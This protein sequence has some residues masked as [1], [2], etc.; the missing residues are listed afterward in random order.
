M[1]QI[2][3]FGV[4]SALA[5]LGLM[6][7][8]G[9]KEEV[10]D[11]GDLHALTGPCAAGTTVQTQSA[12]GIVNF[13]HANLKDG[14]GQPILV[15]ALSNGVKGVCQ[16][17]AGD[18]ALVALN[19]EG[20]I[21][22]QFLRV[23]STGQPLGTAA[24]TPGTALIV[25]GT[26]V[27]FRSVSNPTTV[28]RTLPTSMEVV[29]RGDDAANGRSRVSER[30]L[31]HRTVLSV[32]G[33][34]PPGGTPTG[35]L[36][37]N[38]VSILFP[39]IDSQLIKVTEAG[40]KGALWPQALFT[41]VVATGKSQAQVTFNDSIDPNNI[42]NWKIVSFRYDP[43]FPRMNSANPADCKFELRLVAQPAAGNNTADMTA[44]LIYHP[45]L[46]QREAIA[47]ELLALKKAS[48]VS[49][50]GALG[51]HPG[52]KSNSAA[53][54]KLVKDFVLRNMGASNLTQVAFMGTR[55]SDPWVFFGG[56]VSNGNYTLFSIP[57]TNGAKVQSTFAENSV[58]PRPSGASTAALLEGA[59]PTQAL[60][61]NVMK[62]ENPNVHTQGSVDCVSC[63]TAVRVIERE[64]SAAQTFVNNSQF[65]FPA[66]AGIST[67]VASGQ[68]STQ[69]YSVRNF[70]YFFKQA[71]I[72][73][74]TAN[75][76]AA[77]TNFTNKNILKVP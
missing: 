20:L 49:T 3:K 19:E 69:L 30:G 57:N 37:T 40:A 46:S 23:K 76:S 12:D 74:R 43:C 73:Q 39:L 29:C 48:P 52:L 41:K 10:N 62:I 18:F 2:Q 64:R 32:A 22:K 77:V 34:T 75:E 54:T 56:S 15:R 35:K 6:S 68:L 33:G 67:A 44:H 59:A 63:H 8:C 51:V 38:D 47:K 24:C 55:N 58:T 4:S 72:A 25:T 14:N 17:N 60:V 21:S 66:P 61:D 1:L 70:G 28:L 65:R 50:S 42:A 11:S 31:L 13:R 26:D 53:Y 16:A 5:L 7:G 45:A 71:Q 27:N 9:D 36:E